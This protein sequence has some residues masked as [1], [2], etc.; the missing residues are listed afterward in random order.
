MEQSEQRAPVTLANNAPGHFQQACHN[1]R[2]QRL[3]CDRSIPG[4]AKCVKRGQECLGYGQLFRWQEG[5]ASRGRMT[6]VTFAN[7]VVGGNGCSTSL[8]SDTR[9]SPRKH[10]LTSTSLN[11]LTDPLVQNLDLTSR[12]YLS[13]CESPVP[14]ERERVH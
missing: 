11:V 1:C 3:K 6:G 14:R 12:F 7:E 4:C 9:A 10:D 13:Y 2:R 8:A 5:V